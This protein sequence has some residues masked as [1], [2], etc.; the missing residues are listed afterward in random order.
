MQRPQLELLG[1]HLSW[2]R[3]RALRRAMTNAQ[4]GHG[5]VAVIAI[6]GH[7]Q[8]RQHAAHMAI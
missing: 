6:R 1:W 3:A 4:Q 2:G 8:G 5:D 7:W